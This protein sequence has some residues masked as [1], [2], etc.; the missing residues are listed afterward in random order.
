MFYK[1]DNDAF[2]LKQRQIDALEQALLVS[3][4]TPRAE[5]AEIVAERKRLQEAYAGDP[6]V[7]PAPGVWINPEGEDLEGD[8]PAD[9]QEAI[10]A[11]A[12][13]KDL[14]G[15][16]FST[17]TQWNITHFPDRKSSNA[18]VQDFWE[19]FTTPDSKA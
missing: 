17:D 8:V 10:K 15:D 12:I 3:R 11:N 1:D 19:D 14:L 6:G 4:G 13:A 7:N 18:E 9:R 16:E 2:E 5:A